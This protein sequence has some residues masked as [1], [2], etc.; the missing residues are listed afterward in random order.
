[1]KRFE[2]M[3]EHDSAKEAN[4][5]N[6]AQTDQFQRFSGKRFSREEW[7]ALNQAQIEQFRANNGTMVEGLFKGAPM[8]LLTTNGARSGEARVTPLTY[9]HDGDRYVVLASKLGAPEHPAWYHNLIANPIVTVEVGPE[10]FQAR[11]SVV[12]GSERDR[13][14]DAHATIMP[15]YAEYQR[16]TT[17][18]I[19]VVVL[20]RIAASV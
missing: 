2:D 12:E 11:A 6:Q 13:L 16:N 18:V 15:N 3:T 10:C 4:T 9:T 19:P 20:D 14:F 1:M 8:L 7:N 5:L 17:R